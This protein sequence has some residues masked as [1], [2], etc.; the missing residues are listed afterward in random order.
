M[1]I[2]FQSNSIRFR[3]TPSELTALSEKRGLCEVITFPTGQLSFV[4]QLSD[5]LQEMC[6]RYENGVI[7]VLIPFGWLPEWLSGKKT[8][9][10]IKIPTPDLPL[11]VIVERDFE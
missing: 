11:T 1:K 8:G 5:V 6:S 4:I 2:R 3:L 10:E 9:Y 7:C